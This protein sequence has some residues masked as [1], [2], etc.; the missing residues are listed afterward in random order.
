MHWSR[1]TISRSG[2]RCLPRLQAIDG[3][4]HDE[5]RNTVLSDSPSLYT[6][7]MLEVMMS[8]VMPTWVS[9][10]VRICLARADSTTLVRSRQSMQFTRNEP[11]CSRMTSPWQLQKYL[12]AQVKGQL[13]VV[14]RWL[15]HPES[16]NLPLLREGRP[17]LVDQ[18]RDVLVLHSFA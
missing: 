9:C 2:L 12:R 6:N 17:Q 14:T 8:G 15:D 13:S 4:Q 18:L 1:H 3:I 11:V 7:S 10:E 5:D 16:D